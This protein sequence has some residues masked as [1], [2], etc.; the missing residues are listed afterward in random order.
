MNVE[1]SNFEDPH[2]RL[3]AQCIF[4]MTILLL[5]AKDLL[6]WAEVLGPE[7]GWVI[8][9]TGAE[10][11]QP[12][13][14]LVMVILGLGLSWRGI[15]DCFGVRDQIRK[16]ARVVAVLSALVAAGAIVFAL[17]TLVPSN[18]VLSATNKTRLDRDSRRAGLA[19]LAVA[20]AAVGTF[21]LARRRDAGF[22]RVSFPLSRENE[23]WRLIIKAEVAFRALRRNEEA[24]SLLEQRADFI[25]AEVSAR[26]DRFCQQLIKESAGLSTIDSTARLQMDVGHV[27]KRYA[28]FHA[29]LAEARHRLCDEVMRVT[30]DAVCDVLENKLP[31]QHVRAG[32]DTD[33]SI[34]ISYPVLHDTEALKKRRVEWEETLRGI[35]SAGAA[36]G[37][38]I[39]GDWIDR[40]A[41]GD[42]S[43]DEMPAAVQLIRS[44]SGRS[45][46]APLEIGSGREPRLAAAPALGYSNTAKELH[47]W[48]GKEGNIADPKLAS[49]VR[50]FFTEKKLLLNDCDSP[51]VSAERLMDFLN[52]EFS[53]VL[54]LRTIAVALAR[55]A[56]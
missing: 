49:R 20:C 45:E 12:L 54:T 40:A 33:L 41:R 47:D 48:I 6:A 10:W 11:L 50:S 22:W 13:T 34:S 42:I 39:I 51:E 27:F 4:G 44:L 1:D 35:V 16:R 19:A 14:G 24:I 53:G 55:R 30:H 38:Q 25:Q 8:R 32:T 9:V 7:S 5:G 37:N 29:K 18:H 52:L 36:T 28:D 3:G 23:I 43:A 46:S 17:G 26:F 2:S 15:I 21:F 31:G 56:G